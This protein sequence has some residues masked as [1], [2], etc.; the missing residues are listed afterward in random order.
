[1]SDISAQDFTEIGVK[2]PQPKWLED[3]SKL[4]NRRRSNI[5][6]LRITFFLHHLILLCKM[7]KQM[8]GVRLQC[9]D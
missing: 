6:I 9:L 5:L 1:M 8:D 2:E 4:R 3:V 7:K